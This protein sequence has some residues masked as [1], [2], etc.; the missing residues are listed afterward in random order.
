MNRAINTRELYD[1]RN[2]RILGVI[3][4]FT[5]VWNRRNREVVLNLPMLVLNLSII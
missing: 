4:S 2:P 1:T 5:L 3:N